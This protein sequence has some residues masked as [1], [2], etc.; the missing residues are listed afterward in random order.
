MTTEVKVENNGPYDVQV[1]PYFMEHQGEYWY[2]NDNLVEK[3]ILK[4][5]E[6]VTFHI[7]DGRYIEVKE[8]QPK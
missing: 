8:V 4:P 1:L 7:W 5:G 6:S 2:R 3:K